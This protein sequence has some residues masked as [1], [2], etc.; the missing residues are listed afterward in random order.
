[1][2][3][4]SVDTPRRCGP[5]S[6]NGSRTSAR[7]AADIH[8]TRGPAGGS[9]STAFPSCGASFPFLAVSSA[10]VGNRIASVAVL[11]APTTSA[12]SL[13]SAASSRPG[14]CSGSAPGWTPYSVLVVAATWSTARRLSVQLSFLPLSIRP[15]SP[16][17]FRTWDFARKG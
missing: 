13:L 12:D 16:S 8:R 5:A 6:H 15:L 11:R 17:L 14:H 2:P 7:S 10:V 4:R 3:D 9:S 1:M